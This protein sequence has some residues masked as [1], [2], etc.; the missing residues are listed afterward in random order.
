MVVFVCLPIVPYTKERGALI[1]NQSFTGFRKWKGLYLWSY[2][3]NQ[4]FCKQ[5]LICLANESLFDR[6]KISQSFKLLLTN[7]RV[8]TDWRRNSDYGKGVWLFKEFVLIHVFTR[9]IGTVD[10]WESSN[11]DQVARLLILQSNGASSQKKLRWEKLLF[12][13][14]CKQRKWQLLQFLGTAFS[15]DL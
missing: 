9:N 1:T 3:A 12:R 2:H 11:A 10:S 15:L 5:L 6:R 13:R 7:H 4:S 14:N 8:P